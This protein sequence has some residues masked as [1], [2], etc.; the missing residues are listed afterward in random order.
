METALA[1]FSSHPQMESIYTV[2][3]IVQ[4]FPPTF[5]NS[6]N[7]PRSRGSICD[8]QLS[9]KAFSQ[10]VP[11]RTRERT[12]ERKITSLEDLFGETKIQEKKE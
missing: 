9:L 12:T 2:D 8:L 3:N 4:S 6:I 7:S 5:A 1:P 11:V 10:S